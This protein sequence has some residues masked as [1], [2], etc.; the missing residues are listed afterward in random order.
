MGMLIRSVGSI[1]FQLKNSMGLSIDLQLK[2]FGCNQLL[3]PQTLLQPLQHL[4][5]FKNNNWK[6][7]NLYLQT[8]MQMRIY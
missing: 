1:P 4:K 2:T 8:I 6:N 5:D 7:K 3:A